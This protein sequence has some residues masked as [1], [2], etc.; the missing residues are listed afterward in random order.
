[1]SSCN[2]NVYGLRQN[3]NSCW[4][5]TVIFALFYPTDSYNYL[6]SEFKNSSTKYPETKE[7]YDALIEIV[8]GIRSG[9]VLSK[10]CNKNLL[11]LFKKSI[12]SLPGIDTK[13][14]AHTFI[15]LLLNFFNVPKLE[16][17]ENLTGEEYKIYVMDIINENS[18]IGTVINKFNFSTEPKYLIIHSQHNTKLI[19]N[20]AIDVAYTNESNNTRYK[21][22]YLNSII[23]GSADHYAVY[24][25]CTN[26]GTWLLYDGQRADASTQIMEIGSETTFNRDDK[27]D[28]ITDIYSYRIGNRISTFDFIDTSDVTTS[29]A[30]FIYVEDTSES[31]KINQTGG[32]FYNKYKKYK[33][34]Y[35]F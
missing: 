21:T 19:P 22:L 1:M 34:K 23:A 24:S 8:D 26:T 14:E 28:Y 30:I 9:T 17:S 20:N 12:I 15:K 10:S 25:Y 31:L 29:D 2:T 3:Q 5:D 11:D 27:N 33:Q 16:F 18:S 7:T 13:Y 4:F 6:T 32:Y 35:L